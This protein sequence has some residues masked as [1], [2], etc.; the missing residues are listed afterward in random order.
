LIAGVPQWIADAAAP[1][2]R[3]LNPAAFAPAAA[4]AWQ[5]NLGRNAVRGFGFAQADLSLAREFDLG[6]NRGIE[7]RAEA[8]NALNRPAFGLPVGQMDNPLFGT[9]ASSW[10]AT[11]G[12]GTP[13][14]GLAPGLQVGGPRT[15]QFAV[16]LRF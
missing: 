2:G 7:V 5:G 15:L 11:L 12:T 10:N 6:E 9:A 13:H 1:G 8:Y 4:A 3:R 14:S 16:R